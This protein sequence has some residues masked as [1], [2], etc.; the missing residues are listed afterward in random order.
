MF[1]LSALKRPDLVTTYRIFCEGDFA[2]FL[3]EVLFAE[4]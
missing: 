3:R 2:C 4:T 1:F